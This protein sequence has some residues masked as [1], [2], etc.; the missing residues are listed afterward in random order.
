MRLDQQLPDPVAAHERLTA[1]LRAARC[2]TWR[3]DIV[4]DQVAWDRSL[5]EVY[6][7]AVEAAPRNAAEFLALVHP[8]DRDRLMSTL[9]ACLAGG[10]EVEY[11][12]RAQVDGREVWIYDRSSLVRDP[13]GQPLYMTG[14]CLDVT[15]RKRVEQERDAALE[16]H[17]WLLAEL[18]HRVKN[19]LQ[20]ITAMLA[21]QAA[22]ATPELAAEFEQAIRRIE[23][24]ADLHARLYR[25]EEAVGV[26]DLAAY[27]SD[28]CDGL[29]RSLLDGRPIDLD[30]AAAPARLALDRAVPLGLIVNELVTNAI[31]HG[32]PGGGAGRIAVRLAS[33]G[34]AATLEVSDDGQG[35]I[36]PGTPAEAS[37]TGLGRRLVESMARQIGASLSL[38]QGRG[39]TWRLGFSLESAPA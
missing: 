19:H 20:M 7:L 13:A 26:V 15:E 39:T 10:S 37:G 23:T 21:L 33:D 1:A 35:A 11:E 22:A 8:G 28:I 24:V 3:W 12:F 29:S 36:A 25:D 9:Q 5:C 30:L 16:K 32:F 31:K 18:N 34:Q 4:A 38:V 2:G 17:R 6:G 27:L 14:A